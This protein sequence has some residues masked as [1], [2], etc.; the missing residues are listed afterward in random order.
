MCEI[1]GAVGLVA[2]V[3]A[4]PRCGL[5]SGAGLLLLMF[6]AVVAHVRAKDGVRDVVPAIVAVALC[7]AVVAGRASEVYGA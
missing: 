7:V 4:D 1:G 5:A 2:G 6:G 3:F